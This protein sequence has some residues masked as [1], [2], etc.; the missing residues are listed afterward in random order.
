VVSWLSV[1]GTDELPIVIR[2]TPTAS[3]ILLEMIHL[4]EEGSAIL[5]FQDWGV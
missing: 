5:S 1:S 2:S 4:T 3:L